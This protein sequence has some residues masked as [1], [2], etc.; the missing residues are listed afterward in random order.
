MALA[1]RLPSTKTI[2]LEQLY[3]EIVTTWKLVE[4][5]PSR[6]SIPPQLIPVFSLGKHQ[7]SGRYLMIDLIDPAKFRL[8]GKYATRI[9]FPLISWLSSYI[10]NA[11]FSLIS[12]WRCLIKLSNQRFI[13][14]V[15]FTKLSLWQATCYWILSLKRWEK[16]VIAF[17]GLLRFLNRS[18]YSYENLSIR[19]ASVIISKIRKR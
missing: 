12:K 9:W 5:F 11:Q 18:R 8:P 14:D 15:P 7:L 16:K 3:S 19:R 4:P 2:N 6:A 1:H 17:S 13:F 10:A